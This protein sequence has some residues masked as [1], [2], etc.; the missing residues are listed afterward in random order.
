MTDETLDP[1]ET[2]IYESPK[3]VAHSFAR[4]LAKLSDSKNP[5]RVALSGGSTPRLLFEILA[6]KFREVI[7]W[8]NIH[9]YWGDERCV[10]PDKLES[11]FRVTNDLLFQAIDADWHIFRIRGEEDPEA[12][13]LRYSEEIKSTVPIVNGWPR[14]DLIILGMG[15]D[16]H[17]ASIFPYQLSLLKSD[18]ICAIAK[19]P[20][21]GQKRITLTGNVI[22]N[23]SV[24]AFLVTGASKAKRIVEIRN[25]N[26]ISKLYPASF[27]EPNDGELIWFMDRAAAS[28][29]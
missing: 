16:G 2:K 14:F 21:T 22:N 25:K 10:P 20:E 7:P 17:T 19:H 9:F 5:M 12:E 4:Y 27:I 29:L 13:V 3:A 28:L 8:P 1:M 6:L 26:E 23:A 15:E 11:N 18:Q 24:V